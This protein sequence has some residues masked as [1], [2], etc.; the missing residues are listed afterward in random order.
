MQVFLLV[1]NMYHVSLKHASNNWLHINEWAGP[2]T[3]RQFCLMGSLCFVGRY[4]LSQYK[5]S[6]SL[7]QRT[8]LLEFVQLGDSNFGFHREMNSVIIK[9]SHFQLVVQLERLPVQGLAHLLN[10]FKKTFV[11][12]V[13]SFKLSIKFNT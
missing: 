8:T 4:V 10:K 3:E 9:A 11:S 13:I 7:L 1:Y 5:I 2:N 12:K 6:I